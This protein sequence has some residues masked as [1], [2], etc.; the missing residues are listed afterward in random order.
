[1]ATYNTEQPAPGGMEWH[2]K[3]EVWLLVEINSGVIETKVFE[4]RGVWQVSKH[5]TY[6]EFISCEAAKQ[7][8]N[9]VYVRLPEREELLML[10]RQSF[11]IS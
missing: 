9:K 5:T 4:S 6:R 8:C 2:L 11:G 1:M 3:G 7:Y 10:Q